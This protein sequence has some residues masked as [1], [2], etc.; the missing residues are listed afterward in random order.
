MDSEAAVTSD[1][2]VQQTAG[3]W[4]E[5]DVRAAG[6]SCRRPENVGGHKRVTATPVASVRQTKSAVPVDKSSPPSRGSTASSPAFPK[7]PAPPRFNVRRALRLSS[8][9]WSQLTQWAGSRTSPHRIVVR[10]HIVLLA[11]GG[12]SV[13]GIADR[14]HIAPATVRLWTKRF[15][16]GGLAALTFEAP[17]RG[18]PRGASV[19]ATLAVLQRTRDLH[20]YGLSVRRVAAQATVATSTVW[21]V[22]KRY[23]L[24]AG[25]P[26]AAIES[27]IDKL[28]SE[29]RARR[30]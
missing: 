25:V 29:T 16:S 19:T 23:N 24:R 9:E 13:S 6:R 3:A 12:L 14:L 30:R 4:P 17:G 27:A 5:L 20:P 10:S 8:A 21:R 11:S 28:N 18:R 1:V 26:V 22:W 15:E 2:A 7:I